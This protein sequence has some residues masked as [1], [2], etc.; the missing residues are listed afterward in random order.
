[1]YL[2]GVKDNSR[3]GVV[4]VYDSNGENQY[5]PVNLK[6]ARQIATEFIPFHPE[7]T[8]VKVSLDRDGKVFNRERLEI[9]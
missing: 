3:H 6:S 2:F 4:A 9:I 1:M 8:I 7:I 5:C